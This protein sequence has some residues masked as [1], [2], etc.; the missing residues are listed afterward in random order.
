MSQGSVA[1]LGLQ[2]APLSSAFRQTWQQWQQDWTQL[3]KD[4]EDEAALVETVVELS[5]QASQRLWRTA[6]SRVGDSATDQ[7][8]ALVYAFVALVDETLLF[9]PWPGQAAWQDKPLESRLYSSRQAGEQVPAAIQTLLDEQQPTTRDLANVYLQCLI[10][11]F[12]GRLRGEHSQA[13]LEKWRLALFN[14]AWQDEASYE[15]VS[16]RLVQPSLGTPLQL[17]VRTALPDGFRLALGILAMVLVL[18]GLGQFLW[19]DIR[20]ELEPVLQMTD[21]VTPAEQDS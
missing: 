13:Q 6:Y 2:D 18:T 5:T 12:H 14:F 9:T 15:G 10:L 7:V 21:S 3:P 19:R 20:S 1:G 8:K 17:P 16:Q 11:G 4:S